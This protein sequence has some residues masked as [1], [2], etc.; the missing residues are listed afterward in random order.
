MGISSRH[1]CLP[2]C[3]HVHSLS[4][5]G[6]PVHEIPVPQKSQFLAQERILDE[7]RTTME[8]N[9]LYDVERENGA[10]HPKENEK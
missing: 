9:P 10:M 3:T 5:H 7:K 2:I 6:V 1:T 8:K 4:H